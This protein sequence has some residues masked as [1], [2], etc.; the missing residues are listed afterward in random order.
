MPRVVLDT[1]TVDPL[2]VYVGVTQPSL[3]DTILAPDGTTE[4]LG[5][6]TAVFFMRPLS[7]RTPV[8]DGSSA[9]VIWPV[10]QDGHNV[11][12]DWQSSDVAI[13]GNYS[14]W[15]G[16]V[17]PG[18]ALA[19]TPEFLVVVTDHGP[20]FGTETGVVVEEVAQWMPVTL[21]ALREDPDF[22]DRFLQAHADYVKRVV[23]GQAVAPDLEVDYDPA[24]VEYLSKRTALRLIAPAKDYWGRQYRQVLTQG[25]SESA[26]YPDM[27]KNLDDLCVRLSHE[28]VH[29]WLQLQR[30]VPGL[31]QN[32]VEPS[33]A[34]SL[35][36]PSVPW[37]RHRTLDPQDNDRPRVGGPR[38]GSI[39]MP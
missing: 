17:L 25:P 19:E 13:A 2:V 30:L 36:D 11:R 34:S 7:S 1:S 26:T 37:N 3:Y 18:H 27:L 6:A 28:L 35:G 38:W 32:R 12:Y 39:F 33:P 15:W 5:G 20:G 8:V 22:G 9:T 21:R 4:N 31:P 14:A 10:D 16:Y 24:L 29:D 23:M